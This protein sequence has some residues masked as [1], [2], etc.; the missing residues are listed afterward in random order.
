MA[1]V[2]SVPVSCISSVH[3][4]IFSYAHVLLLSCHYIDAFSLFPDMIFSHESLLQCGHYVGLHPGLPFSSGDLPIHF[5]T[6]TLPIFRLI[7]LT[8]GLPRLLN[9]HEGPMGT[10]DHY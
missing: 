4:V 6:P 3:H 1:E 5:N 9:D 2:F 7:L 10:R 8:L